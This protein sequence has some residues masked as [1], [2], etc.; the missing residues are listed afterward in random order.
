MNFD[1]KERI[2]V[3]EL[4]LA[5]ARTFNWIF[6]EQAVSDVGIDA[7]I[8]LV[9][10]GKAQGKLIAVQIKS[11]DSYLSKTKEGLAF[12]GKNKHLDYWLAHSLSVILVVYTPNDKLLRWIEIQPEN[13]ERTAKHW[14][15]IIPETNIFGNESL[16]ALLEVFDRTTKSSEYEKATSIVRREQPFSA[17]H[18]SSIVNDIA[19]DL[20]LYKWYSWVQEACGEHIP[21]LHESFVEGARFAKV[22][23]PSF[24]FPKDSFQDIAN[25]ASNMINKAN[26]AV[27]LLLQKAEYEPKRKTYSGFHAYKRIYPNPNYDRDNREHVAWAKHFVASFKEFVKSANLFCDI[28]REQLD[29]SFFLKM[30]RLLFTDDLSSWSDTPQYTTDERKEIL[31][32][33]ASQTANSFLEMQFADAK[34][35]D[36]RLTLGPIVRFNMFL[37]AAFGDGPCTCICCVESKDDESAYLNKHTFIFDGR[38]ANRRFVATSASAVLQELRKSWLFYTGHVL[39]AGDFLQLDTIKSFVDPSLRS[40]LA[41]LFLASGIVQHVDGEWQLLDSDR[42]LY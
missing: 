37:K 13:V 28:V 1:P 6:R 27:D 35:K 11:G 42:D 24:I 7:Q 14:K 19:G 10:D 5:V 41:P 40:R 9:I 39:N 16:D 18:V 32:A 22:K 4:G 15:I 3:H 34:K 29:P 30:G 8:E 17:P 25:S 33:G 38:P 21:A 20:Q 23:F 31:D 36:P 26:F 12:Y 2:G